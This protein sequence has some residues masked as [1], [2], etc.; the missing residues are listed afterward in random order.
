MERR[1]STSSF[2]SASTSRRS[3]YTP[4]RSASPTSVQT[5]RTP[6]E[7]CSHCGALDTEG[8]E[9]EDLSLKV[10]NG[11]FV[12]IDGQKMSKK[13]KEKQQRLLS[14]TA[15]SYLQ[16]IMLDENPSLPRTAAPGVGHKHGGWSE[17]KST[18]QSKII[19]DELKIVP[20]KNNKLDVIDTPTLSLKQQ[21]GLIKDIQTE[22]A[23][24]V[25]MN[26]GPIDPSHCMDQMSKL[27]SRISGSNTDIERRWAHIGEA[28]GSSTPRPKM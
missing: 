2:T 1:L 5:E 15:L 13:L 7:L 25:D 4:S 23:R 21:Y 16:N 6:G 9:A 27:L 8:S 20:L 28:Q 14:T 18:N 19:K 24:L 22:L 10:V 12:P 3:T 26:S 11:R 17:L